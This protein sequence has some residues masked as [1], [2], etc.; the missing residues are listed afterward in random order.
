MIFVWYHSLCCDI[1][2]DITKTI[3]KCLSS[4][5]R[6]IFMGDIMYISYDFAPYDIRNLWYH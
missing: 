6:A 3:I 2:Y 4:F 1:L 5:L